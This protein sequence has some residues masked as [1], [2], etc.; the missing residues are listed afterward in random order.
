MMRQRG[1]FLVLHEPFSLYYY[2]SQERK[3]DRYAE[4]SR[5]SNFNFETIFH[6]LIEKAKNQPLFIKDMA[7]YIVDKA[8]PEFL[9]HFE[10]TFLIRDPAKS[11]P[12]L[13]SLWPDFSLI[14]AGYAQ[15]YQLFE[16]TK[17][18][19][20]KNPPVID[21]DDL[22][23]KPEATVKCYC[24]A[25]KIQFIPK[26]LKWETKVP[27]VPKWVENWHTNLQS[28]QGFEQRTKDFQV[29]IEDND[30][31]KKAYDYCFPYYQKMSEYRLRIQ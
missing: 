6:S 14:E 26:A 20:G 2:R 24:D 5:D 15:M 18:F 13:F 12:S 28:T 29:G 21:S 7:Y 27:Q 8:N 11:L 1:D 19:L 9:N 16:L 17:A 10:R 30:Y 25:V 4:Y 22:V 31:L 3:S 23:Q